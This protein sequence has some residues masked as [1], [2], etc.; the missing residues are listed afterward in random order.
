MSH[1]VSPDQLA[2]NRANAA[3]S[4]GPRTPEGKHRSSQNARKH[5]FAATSFAVIRLED[6]NEVAHLREDLVNLH[7]PV[8]S[9]ELFAL[10]RIALAQQAIL[11]AARLEAGFFSQCLSESFDTS[12]QFRIPMNSQLTEEI[13]T[14][15]AQNRNYL[16]SDGFHRLVRQTNSFALLLRYQ[17]Q[18][19]R[20][21]RRAIEEFDRLKALREELPNEPNPAEAETNETTC[22][23]CETNPIP[24][25]DP[26]PPSAPPASASEADPSPSACLPPEHPS[27]P[28]LP[29]VPTGGVH[30]VSDTIEP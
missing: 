16:L 26:A 3:S 27:T 30:R 24:P 29:P 12:G 11:R 17:A 5:G 9:Q 21:Y 22:P 19:E 8:N 1:T 2:A 10:E 25:G 13:E 15:Q 20:Q 28:P 6:L 7:H 23:S 14:C 18:A 4:T